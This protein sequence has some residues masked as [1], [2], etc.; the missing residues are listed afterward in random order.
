MAEFQVTLEDARGEPIRGITAR[1]LVAA[2]RTL[3][4]GRTDSS[5]QV[6][7]NMP[8]GAAKGRLE[9]GPIPNHWSIADKCDVSKDPSRRFRAESLSSAEQGFGWWHRSVGVAIGREAR[10]KGISI[11]VIDTGCG[12][13]PALKHVEA[14]GT[15]IDGHVAAG[16]EDE[17]EHGSHV[18][19][20]ITA[21][22]SKPDLFAG[23][24]PDARCMAARVSLPGRY[25]NQGDI[26]DALDAIVKKGAHLVNL[27]LAAYRPSPALIDSIAN[28]WVN[29]VVC[30]ASAGNDGGDVMWP[31][32]HELVV[33]VTA[34]GRASEVPAG[35]IA[36]LLLDG[37]KAIDA[38]SNF[39]FPDFCSRG[40]GVNCCAPGVGIVSTIR[41]DNSSAGGAWADM[42]GSSMASPL[43]LGVL[44]CLLSENDEYLQMP[45]DEERSQKAIEILET[46]C[47]PL[48]LLEDFQGN[49]LLMLEL[50]YPTI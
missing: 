25:A 13:H 12:P 37:A 36:H 8:S 33:A 29:G 31:A 19:G 9:I 16:I 50:G 14:V 15:F 41:S 42:S 28:A 4:T 21:S 26:A 17:G 38:A 10:G 23:I 27:S 39:V 3:L 2:T 5:G 7:W 32:R 1:F 47:L 49:G 34:L 44:A 22:P 40:L 30:F 20:I 43:A 46:Q 48:D 45:A 11:G 18:C 24:A 35:S 6:R